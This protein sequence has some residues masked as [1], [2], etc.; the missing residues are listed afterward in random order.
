MDAVHFDVQE[1]E[2]FALLGPS[3][4]GKTTTLRMIAGFERPDSGKIFLD[5]VEIAGESVDTPVEKRG[6]GFVFQDHALFPHLTVEKNVGFGLRKMSKGEKSA[7]VKDVIRMVGLSG[8]EARL[9]AELSGGQQ[10][11]VAL[12]RA[13]APS[14]RILLLDEPFANLDSVLRESMRDEMRELIRKEGITAILVTHDQEE[15]LGFA[16][17]IAVMRSGRIDQVGSPEHVYNT[18][19]SLF[20]AQFLGR[21]NL[22]MCEA[23]GRTADTSLGEI[24]LNRDAE[25]QVLVSLRPEHIRLEGAQDGALIFSKDFKGHD[26]SYGVR[27]DNIEYLVHVDSLCSFEVGDRVALNVVREG[28][29]LESQ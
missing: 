5:G 4:C 20:V 19:R 22:L 6:I 9:P 16:D 23:N 8:Y 27:Q 25:G 10:Q 15:A 17:R 13:I 12:A 14:P 26:I 18:P 3:G 2:I 29:V 21:T 28:V 11:R 1:K 24:Q 7:R